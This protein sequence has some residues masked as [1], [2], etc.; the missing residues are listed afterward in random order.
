[1]D[2]YSIATYAYSQLSKATAKDSLKALCVNL[3]RYGALAQQYKNYCTD[4]LADAQLTEEQ[5]AYLTDPDT[6]SFDSVNRVLDDLSNA[7]VSWVGKSLSLDSKVT[8]KFIF[9]A[10]SYTGDPSALSLRITYRNTDGETV[11]ATATGAEVYT[12]GTQRYFI[13]FDGLLA[14]EL[15]STV[16]VAVYDGNTRV[17]PTL[18]YSASSYGNGKTGTLLSLCRALMAYSDMAKAFFEN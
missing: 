6:V 5:K 3:L 18:E 13:D 12:A 4:N 15:R 11:T 10:S 1:M 9:D 16:S 14:A 2:S 17:S 7:P 8:L